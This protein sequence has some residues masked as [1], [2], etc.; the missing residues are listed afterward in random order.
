MMPDQDRME[1]IKD[2]FLAMTIRDFREL[3]CCLAY[4]AAELQKADVQYELTA[5]EVYRLKKS[6]NGARRVVKKMVRIIP[7]I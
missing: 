7:N 6:I 3:S 2:T 1:R 5:E 4:Y